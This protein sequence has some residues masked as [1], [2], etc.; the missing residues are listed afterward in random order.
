MPL[1][2]LEAFQYFIPGYMVATLGNWAQAE[3]IPYSIIGIGG[4]ADETDAVLK[5]RDEYRRIFTRPQL[6]AIVA[7]LREMKL[8]EEWSYEGDEATIE[9]AINRILEEPT[10]KFR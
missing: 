4:S 5:E 2:T 3:M 8:S 10:E 1:L 9:F 7:Y 6:E